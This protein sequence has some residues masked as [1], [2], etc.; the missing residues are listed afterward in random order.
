[1]DILTCEALVV[2]TLNYRERDILL[3]V[4]TPSAGIVR[5]VFRRARGGRAPRAAATQLL[6]RIRCTIVRR[7]TAE[8]ADF[9]D[10]RPVTS[11]FALTTDFSAMTAVAAIAELFLVFCPP[12]EPAPR[13]FRLGAA[14]LDA[15]LAGVG[16]DGALSYT[17]L[18]TLKL[19]GFLPPLESCSSCGTPLTDIA[20]A[21]S[22]GEGLLCPHCASSGERFGPA[23]LRTLSAWVRQPPSEISTEPPES[24]SRWLDRTTQNAAER[25]LGALEFHR[26]HGE[27]P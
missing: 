11:S 21:S 12:G 5:G 24:V 17:Q 16:P 3:S 20:V 18:W 1:M 25:R 14:V 26:T 8:L 4:L 2:D 15:L 9:R 22:L 23:E 6:S 7:P 13:R 27:S 19:G 10:I